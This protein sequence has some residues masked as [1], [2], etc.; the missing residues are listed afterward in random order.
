MCRPSGR[1]WTVMPCAPASSAAFASSTTLGIDKG[2]W[3]RSKAILLTLT[4]SA[5]VRRR[6]SRPVVIRGF[7]VSASGRERLCVEHD[8]PRAQGVGAEMIVKLC[9]QDRPQLGRR[10]GR[11]LAHCFEIGRAACRERG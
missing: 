6:A 1:G 8:L 5:V 11:Y 3:L 4:D 2:R 9:A 10:S 7:I